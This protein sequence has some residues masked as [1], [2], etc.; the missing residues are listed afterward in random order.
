M[1]DQINRSTEI[2]PVRRETPFKGRDVLIE[3]TF[4]KKTHLA[5]RVGVVECEKIRSFYVLKIT[6]KPPKNPNEPGWFRLIREVRGRN[7]AKIGRLPDWDD[8][9][10]K[11]VGQVYRTANYVYRFFV[12]GE[13]IHGDECQWR[14]LWCQKTSDRGQTCGGKLKIEKGNEIVCEKCGSVYPASMIEGFPQAR[15]AL[16]DNDANR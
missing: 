4:G 7:K 12:D 3:R 5:G 6:Q 9:T 13:S 8:K 15:A 2:P 11:E 16:M 14:P 1:V 10:I